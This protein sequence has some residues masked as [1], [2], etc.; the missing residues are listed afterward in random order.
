MLDAVLERMDGVENTR[1]DDD[2]AAVYEL[3]LPSRGER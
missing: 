2:L 3:A 1:A